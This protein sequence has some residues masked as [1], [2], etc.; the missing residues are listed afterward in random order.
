MGVNIKL[1]HELGFCFGVKQAIDR[2]KE[3]ADDRTIYTLGSLVHNEKVVH[4]LSLLGIKPVKDLAQCSGVVAITAHGAAPEIFEEAAERQ[5]EV[6]DLTCPIVKKAQRICN[7]LVNRG[8]RVVIFGDATHN[9]VKG[10][11]GWCEGKG[12]ALLKSRTITAAKRL[13]IVSQTTQNR[14]SFFS[15]AKN[16]LNDDTGWSELEVVDT[17]CQFVHRRQVEA[18]QIAQEV[19]IMLVIGS[20]ASANT[21]NLANLCK[22]YCLTH[23][24]EGV[25]DLQGLGTLE[26]HIGVCAGT[27]TPLETIMEVVK[28]IEGSPHF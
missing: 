27:S 22:R 24:I 20:R 25:N 18:E 1:A 28:E 2:A 5:L 15:F 4:D 23:H 16:F 8:F 26:G 11:L 12:I 9:E 7:T 3:Q 6:I 13:A 10:L 19:D 14:K 21:V 17:T